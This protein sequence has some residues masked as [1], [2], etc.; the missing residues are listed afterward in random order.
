MPSLTV[1]VPIFNGTHF[2]P[3][4]LESLKNA[5]P[6]NTQ[7]IFIDD[8]STESVLDQIPTRLGSNITT[9]IQNEQNAGYSVT[10]NR[11][12]DLAGGDI[13]IQLNTDLILDEKCITAM[14][15]FIQ[16]TP[17]V[18]IVG[19]KLLFPTTGLLQ[20]IG[21]AFGFHSKRHIYKELPGDHP[22]SNKTRSMQI[23]TGA[24]VAMT[25]YV[26]NEIG[27]LDERFFNYNED[28]DHCM[29]AHKLGYVNYTCAESMAYHWVSQSGPAR[30][31]KIKEAE[32]IFWSNWSNSYEV[33]LNLYIDEALEYVLNEN[34]G[35]E[36]F[37]FTPL[38]LCRSRD[39]ELLLN[40]IEARWPASKA[41]TRHVGPYNNPKRK[42]WLPMELPHRAVLAPYPY[43]YLVDCYLDLSEN[44]YWFR[45]RRQTVKEELI[46][47]LSGIAMTTSEFLANLCE[48]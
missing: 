31:A 4:F 33:D 16:T 34:P 8:G 14:V 6:H 22:L 45:T 1:I 29:K 7:L 30:F 2:L 11:G 10:V 48:M 40:C 18:G 15:D 35:V 42:L 41:R 5:V 37:S 3:M 47:D 46:L 44:I 32:A 19:S 21:M 17:K 25:R 28:L 13:I 36:V 12:F 38:N 26:L 24:T 27:P 39:D 20:H 9:K 23:M 43:I